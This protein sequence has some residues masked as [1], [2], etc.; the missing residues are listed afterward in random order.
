MD[1]DRRLTGTLRGQTDKPD[2]P[3][4]FEL[5][6][7]WKVSVTGMFQATQLL[8]VQ[9]SWRH[10]FL[11]QRYGGAGR[12]TRLRKPKSTTVNIQ[13]GAEASRHRGLRTGSA[14]TKNQNN[15]KLDQLFKSR[16]NIK[17]QN[18]L[19]VTT[20]VSLLYRYLCSILVQTLKQCTGLAHGLT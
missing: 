16:H 19:A 6:N 9:C 4:G 7:P 5:N 3:L 17:Y 13:F 18:G 11:E 15:T 2:A 12:T 10:A 20:W 14:K 8:T 1:R